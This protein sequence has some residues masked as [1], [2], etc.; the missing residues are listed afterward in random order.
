METFGIVGMTFGIIGMGLA[1]T[2]MARIAKLE[3]QLKQ[4]GVPDP[5]YQAE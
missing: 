1:S 5:E 4:S 3:A 2:A